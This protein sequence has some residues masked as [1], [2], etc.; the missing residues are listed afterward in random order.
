[1]RFDQTLAADLAAIPDGPGENQGIALGRYVA[2]QMLAWRASDGS[3]ASGSY[4]LRSE[5]GQWRPTPPHF[6][7]TPGTPQRPSATPF[8]LTSGDQFRPG[9]PPELTSA[10]YTEA[11]QQ[12]KA[13]GGDGVTTPS[14]RTPEQTQIALF[15]GV[16]PTNGG[17]A[18]WN[19]IAETV[20][21]ARGTTLAQ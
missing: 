18:I 9:P 10:D 14:A 3:A 7:Q 2:A 15:W 12:I 20:A 19:R 13:L 8:A 16:G 1:A 4:Q 5:P 17:V 6:A 11:F 21:S